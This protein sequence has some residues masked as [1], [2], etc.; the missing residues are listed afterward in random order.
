MWKWVPSWRNRRVKKGWKSYGRAAKRTGGW[1]SRNTYGKNNLAWRGFTRPFRY[2]DLA[3]RNRGGYYPYPK[4]GVGR[5]GG[6]T[7]FQGSRPQRDGE[8]I[9]KKWNG[10]WRWFYNEKRR[11]GSGSRSGNGSPARRFRFRMRN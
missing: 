3:Y 1:I 10:V 7:P 8:W 9:H 2:A 5:K 4:V 6:F 11:P